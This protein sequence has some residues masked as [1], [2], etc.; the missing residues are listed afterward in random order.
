[1]LGRHRLFRHAYS[2][3]SKRPGMYMYRCKKYAFVN[4]ANNSTV[5]PAGASTSLA[6]RING[7]TIHNTHILFKSMYMYLPRMHL[8]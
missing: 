2:D 1:M 5:T 8:Q 7:M 6:S 4:I 3:N